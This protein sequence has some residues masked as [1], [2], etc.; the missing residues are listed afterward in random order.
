MSLA[1]LPYGCGGATVMYNGVPS[2]YC[3]G[4]YYTPQQ[5]GTTVVYVVDS[6]DEGANTDVEFEE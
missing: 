3:G 5:Q 6:I 4:V 2:Y 1:Y